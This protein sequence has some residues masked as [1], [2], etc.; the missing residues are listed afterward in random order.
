MQSIASGFGPRLVPILG[1]QRPAVEIGGGRGRR[2]VTRVQRVLRQLLEA[3]RVDEHR[4]V[5]KQHDCLIAQGDTLGPEHATGEV[6]G[7]VQ[8]GSRLVDRHVGPERVHHL[9]A[10]QLPPR[11]QGEELDE[12]RRLP[13]APGGRRDLSGRR[14]VRRSDPEGGSP[15][16]RNH[17]D[18]L[19]TPPSFATRAGQASALSADNASTSSLIPELSSSS[20]RR[21]SHSV[22]R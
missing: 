8:P 5:R 20:S 14:P 9:L 7:L 15:R 13:A 17:H 4:C 1:K 3:D 12:A 6:R 18:S 11:S 2:R 22:H 10:V 19:A 16:S 21:T